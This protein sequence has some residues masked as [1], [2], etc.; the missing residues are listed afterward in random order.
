MSIAD[1][2]VYPNTTHNQAAF[3]PFSYGPA[4]CVGKYFA[5]TEMRMVVVSIMQKFD[6]RFADSYNPTEWEANLQD[7]YVMKKGPLPV[8]L[9]ARA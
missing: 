5:M 4:N 1:H 2:A 9:T 8:V 7:F 6:I 3:L